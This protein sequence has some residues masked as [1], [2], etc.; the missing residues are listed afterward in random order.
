MGSVLWRDSARC[1]H[2][3][4]G[5]TILPFDVP[6]CGSLLLYLGQGDCGDRGGTW[7]A[8]RKEI[9]ASGPVK[10]NRMEPNVL[11]VDYVDVTAGGETLK[12]V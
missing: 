2:Q 10:V 9:A 5:V 7:R 3:S 1:F 8:R 11:T 6:P 4:E 12:N